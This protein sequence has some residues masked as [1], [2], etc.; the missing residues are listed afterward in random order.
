MKRLAI[1]LLVAVI[2]F[3]GYSQI[4][5]TPGEYR[6]DGDFFFQIEDYSEALFNFLQLEGTNLMNDNIKYKIGLCYLNI[7]GEEYKGIPY[8]EEAS[9]NTTL[10]YKSKSIKEKQ[11]P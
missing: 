4:E 11:A 5:N 8:L 7:T 2:C 9:Q 10:K 6:D 3:P 1:L